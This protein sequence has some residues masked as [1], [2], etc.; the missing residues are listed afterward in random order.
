MSN[1]ALRKPNDE[2]ALQRQIETGSRN[3]NP[4][5]W[6]PFAWDDPKVGA[7]VK[8]EVAVIRSKGTS[9]SLQAGLWRTGIGISGCEADGSCHVDYSAPLGDE[10]I[11]IL[12][13]SVTVTIAATGKKYRLEAGSMISH[14]KGVVL[15]WDIDPPFLKKFWV[16]WDSPNPATRETDVFVGNISDNPDAWEAY[17][18]VEPDHGPQTCGELF[19]LR[20]TG[21]TG[22][23]KCGLW[24]TGVGIAGC[25]PDGSSTIPYTA[26]LGDETMLLLEGQVHMVNEETGE[27]YHLKA[28]DIIALPSGLKVT[29][30]SKAPFVKKFWIITN[31]KV[32]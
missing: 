20:S 16:I 25:E 23:L 10:T 15:S 4:E 14:P 30:T 12:E 31:E 17:K 22:S 32:S 11:V 8:G 29:W 18:W 1:G 2:T 6:V 7:Q 27:E 26:P 3:Y 24:R 9:G 5:K 13:G 28:G 19:A 21:S